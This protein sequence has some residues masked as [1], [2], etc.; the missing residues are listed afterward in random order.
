M[1]D[2]GYGGGRTS[3]T[4]NENSPLIANNNSNKKKKKRGRL[5]QIRRRH[6]RRKRRGKV[7]V[8]RFV[9]NAFADVHVPVLSIVGVCLSQISQTNLLLTSLGICTCF[10]AFFCSFKYD[11]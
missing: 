11:S 9:Y 5:E 2:D 10:S 6:R 1:T 7:I 8:Q 3:L 4:T